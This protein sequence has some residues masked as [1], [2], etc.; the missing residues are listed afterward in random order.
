MRPLLVALIIWIIAVFSLGCTGPETA[1]PGLTSTASPPQRTVAPQSAWEQ[2]WNKV[3][4]EAK[5]EG[6]VVIAGNISPSGNDI[7]KKVLGEQFQITPEFI[8]GR[9]PEVV[10]KI[11][12]EQNAGLYLVDVIL[13]TTTSVLTVLKPQGKVDRMDTALILPEVTDPK[14][15]YNGEIPWVDK[16][17]R[18]HLAFFAIPRSGVLVN[19]DLV[20][21]KDIKSYYDFLDPRWKGKIVVDD[22][23]VTGSGIGWFTP[24]ASEVGRDYFT[25]LFALEPAV[26]RDERLMVEWVARGKYPVLLGFNNDM[27]AEF[28]KAGAPIVGIQM[29]EGAYTSQSNGAVSLAAK[30]PHLNA[31]KVVINWALS[32]EGSTLLSQ[33]SLAQSAR[34]DVPTDFLPVDGIRQ[35]GINYTDSSTED[36]QYK[37]QEYAKIAQEIFGP[38]LKK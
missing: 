24:L 6:T 12:N 7:L 38:Y 18:Y 5:R 10:T 2:E 26:T 31:A 33:A 37:K 14:V 1:P 34:K 11:I 17:K 30:A 28:I 19:T 36:Y 23:T 15:W 8:I 9:G 3:R 16:E 21:P 29:K 32:K 4:L 20:N 27:A 35:P 22:P 25:K 13:A